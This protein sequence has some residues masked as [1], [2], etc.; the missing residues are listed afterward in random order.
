MDLKKIMEE[1]QR[2]N[3]EYASQEGNEADCWF[4]ASYYANFKPKAPEPAVRSKRGRKITK[5]SISG[6][7]G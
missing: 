1:I 6:P 3:I 7:Q 4:S 2:F 5:D